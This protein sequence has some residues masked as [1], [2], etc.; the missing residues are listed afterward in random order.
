MRAPEAL[1][2]IAPRNRSYWLRSLGGATVA[3][4]VSVAVAALGRSQ[5]WPHPLSIAF[6]AFLLLMPVLQ[7]PPPG[8]PARRLT[9]RLA[10]GIAFA[11]IGGLLHAY[12]LD[13]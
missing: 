10:L 11:L 12:V 4:A 9:A 6:A 3:A 7:P 8:Y 13:R 5:G 1:P 2:N